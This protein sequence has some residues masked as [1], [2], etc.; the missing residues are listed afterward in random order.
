MAETGKRTTYYLLNSAI[1][2]V[3]LLNGLYCKVLDM[4]PRHRQIVAR[5]LVTDHTRGLTLTIGILEV[6]MSMWIVSRIRPRLC[7]LMQITVVAVMNTMEALLVPELLLFGYGNAF[8][9]LVFIFVV[10]Y[11]T[12]HL[13]SANEH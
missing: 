6:L 10:Y 5:I 12:F 13:K 1:A 3:W 9:A 11:T 8:F 7:A 4:V 2:L